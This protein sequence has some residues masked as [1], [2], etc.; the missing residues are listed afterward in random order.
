MAYNNYSTFQRGLAE[1]IFLKDD[2]NEN[3][4]GQVWPGP[5]YFPD[6]LN[7]KGKAWWGNEIAEFHRRVPFDG[8]WIDMN[9]VSNFCNGT[10]CKF[11]GVVYLDHN[12]CYV[13]CE[14]PTSQW[15]DPP[16]KMIRQGAYDNIGDKTIAMNVKHYD[17][18]LEYNSHN[19]Y[20]LSEAIATNEALKATRK[21]R[22]FV[23]SR[24]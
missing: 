18:T 24:Y 5:V 7:P 3:Y 9:E 15:S 20:G 23:L 13:E 1:D 10:R 2:Q 17:G 12:E 21:K 14:K 11:N 19:L 6:F 22:P 16:Y 4:L 8:L